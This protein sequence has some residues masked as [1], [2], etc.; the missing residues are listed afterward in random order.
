MLMLEW[1]AD[2]ASDLLGWLPGR[3]DVER[4]QALAAIG[5]SLGALLTITLGLRRFWWEQ[6]DGPALTRSSLQAALPGAI[7]QVVTRVTAEL[8][9]KASSVAADPSALT[10]DM[11][12]LSDGAMSA[13]LADAVKSVLQSSEPD[14]AAAVGA[15]ERG[16]S[17]IAQKLLAA[18]AGTLEGSDPGGAALALHRQAALATL[19]DPDSAVEACRRAVEI[20]PDDPSGWSQLAHLFLRLGRLQEAKAA[21]EMALAVAPRSQADV[22]AQ[23]MTRM[24]MRMM[25]E[26]T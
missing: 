14:A 2:V 11:R 12:R 9:A 4:L 25:P 15:L 19:T 24:I 3:T 5:A 6:R 17:H 1:L 8:L 26:Q 7:D 13:A 22:A 18:R 10:G 21:F 20:H 23:N 16:D